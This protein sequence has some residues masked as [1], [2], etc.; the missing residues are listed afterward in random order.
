MTKQPFLGPLVPICLQPALVPVICSLYHTPIFCLHLNSSALK[1]E[2]VCSF[3]TPKSV[4]QITLCYIAE[5]H[6]LN[7]DPQL[8]YILTDRMGISV[9][10]LT[11]FQLHK[12]EY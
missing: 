9:K 6:G 12:K 10:E 1:L 2:A 8:L 3:E 4:C 11:I 7:V 5:D